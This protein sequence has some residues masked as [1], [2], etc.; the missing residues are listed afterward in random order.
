MSLLTLSGLSPVTLLV[1]AL[2]A[3]VWATVARV[4]HR[5]SYRQ[6]PVAAALWPV[7]IPFALYAPAWMRRW[8]P[9]SARG[10]HGARTRHV[11][12]PAAR[13]AHW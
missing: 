5:A 4:I 10:L 3:L 7:A 1:I 6:H 13:I 9:A 8:A 2:V 11:S 12:R